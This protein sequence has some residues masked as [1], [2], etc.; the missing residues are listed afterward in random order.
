MLVTVIIAPG[1]AALAP[2]L[3]RLNIGSDRERQVRATG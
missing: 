2:V 1:A 3:A